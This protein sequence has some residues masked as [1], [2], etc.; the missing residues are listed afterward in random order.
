[1]GLCVYF[2][3]FSAS[4]SHENRHAAQ[5]HP[6]GRFWA[7]AGVAF[8]LMSL[9]SLGSARAL[10]TDPLCLQHLIPLH[11]SLEMTELSSLSFWPCAQPCAELLPQLGDKLLPS[12]S[13]MPSVP[14]MVILLVLPTWSSGPPWLQCW[15]QPPPALLALGLRDPHLKPPHLP[16]SCPFHCLLNIP[17]DYQYREPSF[18]IE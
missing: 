4:R 16:L 9:S 7:F 6:L 5:W 18:R 1:M 3:G 11:S 17:W 15:L 12:C 14:G 10:W 8:P 13:H 2:Q